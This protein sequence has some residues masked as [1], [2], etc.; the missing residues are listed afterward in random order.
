MRAALRRFTV[1]VIACGSVTA[2]CAT[3]SSG[4]LRP[5]AARQLHCAENEITFEPVGGDCLDKP[6]SDAVGVPRDSDCDV[7]A[8]GC[9]HYM[10]FIHAPRGDWYEVR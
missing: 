7:A 8:R 4:E 9:D 5:W 10:K 1:F 2:S 6:F 3:T